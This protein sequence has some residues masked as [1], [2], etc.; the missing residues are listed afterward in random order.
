MKLAIICWDMVGQMGGIGTRLN[1]LREG[2]IRCDDECDILY[3]APNVSEKPGLFKNRKRIANKDNWIWCDGLLPHH[4]RNVQDSVDFVKQKYDAICYGFFCPSQTKHYKDPLFMPLV[5]DTELPS[6]AWVSDGNFDS[7]PEWAEEVLVYLEGVLCPLESYAI[8][9]RNR[10]VEVTIS[11]FPFFPC[12]KEEVPKAEN[13]LMVWPNQWKSIKGVEKFVEQ[14][15]DLAEMGIDVELYSCGIDYYRMAKKKVWG[16]GIGEDKFGKRHGGGEAIYF[17]TVEIPTLMDAFQRAHFTCN[18]QGMNV[19]EETYK[20]GSYNNCEV[21]ALYYGACPVLHQS[22]LKTAIPKEL[23]LTVE[24]KGQLPGVLKEALES[25]VAL[26]KQRQIRAREW[27][28]D[29]H[30]GTDRYLDM[31][32]LLDGR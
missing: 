2:A 1:R 4:P 27:V 3:S 20:Q 28:I 14:L 7:Y 6:V 21:E 10:G 9:L 8:P 11:A 17:G 18:F 22:V 16:Y 29:T 26:D 19:R 24:Y 31:R 5:T 32:R 13:P 30:W 23:Y 25:N 12:H 15:P